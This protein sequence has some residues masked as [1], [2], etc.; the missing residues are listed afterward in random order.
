[1]KKVQFD[2]NVVLDVLHGREPH[3]QASA[4]LWAAIEDGM[5][6]GLVSAHAL[7]TIHYLYSRNHDRMTGKRAIQMIL[8]VLTVAAVD[9]NIIAR[10]LAFPMTDFEDAV[11]AAAAQA[12]GC[13]FIATRD[14]KGFRGSPV[15]ALA[16]ESIVPLL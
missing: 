13:D 11:T 3:F 16:P 12:A 1:M 15:M 9:Q 4:A 8:Q 7:T 5:A 6:Y 2:T 14:P 10:A